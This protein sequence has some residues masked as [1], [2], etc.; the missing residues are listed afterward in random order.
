MNETVR[1]RK[2]FG[3]FQTP[4]YLVDEVCK[5][6]NQLEVVADNIIEPTCGIGGFVISALKNFPNKK[7]FGFEI[8]ESYIEIVNQKLTQHAH[9]N[10]KITK[11]DFF[12]TDWKS[13]ISEMAGSILILGN[14]PWVTNS[15]QGSLG[16][17]NLPEKNNFQNFKGFDAITG[18]A[19]FDISEWMLLESMSWLTDRPGAIAMLVKT[20]VARKVISHAEKN[21][22]PVTS[23]KIFK[24]NA[25]AAFDATVDACLLILEFDKNKPKNYDYSVYET[26]S[27][28]KYTIIGHRDGLTV[29]NLD[30]YKKYSHLIGNSSIKWRSGVKHDL[31]S[32][33]E[34]IKNGDKIF[35]GLGEEVD[36]ESDLL[37][38]LMKGSDIGGKKE[39][40]NKYVL[41]TQSFV[42]ENTSYIKDKY[43]KTWS[44]LISHS[45]KLD[46]RGSVIYTK[47]PRFSIFG[48][49]DYTFKPWKIAI[50]GLYKSLN[51]KLIGTIEGKP[52]V[53]DDTVY[54][55][56]FDRQEDAKAAL[57]HL[58]KNEVKAILDSL[59]FWYDKRP[60][61]TGV[62]NMLKWEEASQQ[63]ALTF[64]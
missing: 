55:I 63:H 42:G 11:S 24:I 45:D 14:F 9:H 25:K 15:T 22:S 46:A 20:A 33:M 34:L 60:I 64:S 13:T 49:G 37:F 26:L 61:K 48:V 32:V 2:E 58:Q 12:S 41:V 40:R 28:E 54:F 7:I 19:N 30:N 38:P 51:F 29:S 1:K 57:R 10:V 23:A 47:S 18:K 50:C 16:S 35:N 31:S 8:N 59:I 56:S 52:T 44:Y 17:D 36:I 39:W 5:K 21:K 6:L 27:S 43:P 53:F 3:D 62:L 4:D